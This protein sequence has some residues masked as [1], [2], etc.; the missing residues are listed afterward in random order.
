MCMWCI[1]NPAKHRVMGCACG[2]IVVGRG[3]WAQC[4]SSSTKA[5]YCKSFDVVVVVS[6]PK[7]G[8]NCTMYHV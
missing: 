1:A 2:A 7:K 6:P 5:P 3:P 4:A 8:K